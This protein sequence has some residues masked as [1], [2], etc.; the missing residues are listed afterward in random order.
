MGKCIRKARPVV[1]QPEAVPKAS[2]LPSALETWPLHRLRDHPQQAT[3][4]HDLEGI[5]FEEFVASIRRE[6]IKVPIEVTPE[7]VT[8]DGHQRRR[9][10]ERLGLTEVPVLVRHDLTGDPAASDRAHLKANLHRRQLSP[11]DQVRIARRLAEIE[12]GRPAS[13]MTTRELKALSRHVSDRMGLSPRHVQRLLNISMLPMSIQKAFAAGGLTVVEADRVSR[14]TVRSQ[15]KIAAEIEAGEDPARIVKPYFAAQKPARELKPGAAFE[16]LLADLARGLD[17][18]EGREEE[19]PLRRD[20]EGELALLERFRDYCEVL[21]V[22]IK[23]KKEDWN[24][25]LA[26]FGAGVPGGDSTDADC[27]QAD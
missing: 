22:A 23:E 24:R 4:F 9:A 12:A 19:L 1:A 18:L 6:G 2:S 27:D 13:R 7:G 5:E 8:I 11:I 16:R 17:T 26:E 25:F 3:I 20:L 10:A 14:L 15:E 21:G